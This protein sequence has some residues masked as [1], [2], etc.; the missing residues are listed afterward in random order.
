MASIGLYRPQWYIA[1]VTVVLCAAFFLAA[2]IPTQAA[3]VPRTPVLFVGMQHFVS[4][5]NVYNVSVGNV[6]TKKRQTEIAGISGTLARFRP[7]IVVVER[8]HGT[9]MLSEHYRQFLRG[10]FILPA[11]EPYQIGFRVAKTAKVREIQDIDY[12]NGFPYDAVV[13]YANEHGQRALLDACDRLNRRVIAHERGL[14]RTGTLGDV[15]RYIN[16]PAI[17]RDSAACY[18]YE[19][20]IGDA[21]HPVGPTLLTD[22][23]ARNLRLFANLARLIHGPH[24]RVLILYGQGHEYLMQQFIAASPNLRLINPNAYL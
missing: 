15:L 2:R 7:T 5:A 22:W 11:D 20:R 16:E 18:M 4:R 14:L 24:E 3:V 19:D 21:S 13:D 17:V 10:R 9:S 23:Y 8:T 12:F 6:L 1:L